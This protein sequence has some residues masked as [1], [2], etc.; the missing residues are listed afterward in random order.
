MIVID[1]RTSNYNFLKNNFQRKWKTF[2]DNKNEQFFL[3]LDEPPL[4]K[5]NIKQ[6]EFYFN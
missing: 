6:N 2:Q 3:I 4:G 5:L 1:G